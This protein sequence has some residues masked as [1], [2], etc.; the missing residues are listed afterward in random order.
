[1]RLEG[2]RLLAVGASSGI[3]KAGALAAAAEGARVCFAARRSDPIEEAARAAG[4]GAFA[5]PC[6]V[7]DESACQSVVAEAVETMGGLDAVLYAPGIATLGPIHEIDSASWHAVLETNLIGA[8]L[9]L[10]ASISSLEESR[11]K[12]LFVSSIV[13]DD[14]PPRVQQASYIVSKVALESLITAW[15]TEHHDVG[16]TSIATGDTLTDFGLGLELEKIGPIVRQWQDHGYLYGRVMDPS[17][18]AEQIVHALCSTETIRRIA[19]TPSY[20]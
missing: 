10:N 13:I 17:T 4:Q 9:I 14:S 20:R 3:G 1:M 5:L 19:I 18:V 7:R 11:G 16:F 6:D 12:A 15:Q 8:S 2:K